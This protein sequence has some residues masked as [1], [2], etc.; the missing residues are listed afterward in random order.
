MQKI[1]IIGNYIT[2]FGELWNRSLESLFE[3][4][5]FGSLNSVF[6]S[7]FSWILEVKVS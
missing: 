5:V 3:E 4:A 2:K 6:G 7:K 1:R